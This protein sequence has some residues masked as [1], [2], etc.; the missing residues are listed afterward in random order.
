MNEIQGI[1]KQVY[2][3]PFA[4]RRNSGWQ[5]TA[6]L[7][8]VSAVFGK[9]IVSDAHNCTLMRQHMFCDCT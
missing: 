7:R 2:K 4:A 3:W 8:F 6:T 1:I 5:P 9:F